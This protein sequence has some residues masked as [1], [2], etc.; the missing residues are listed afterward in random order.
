MAAELKRTVLIIDSQ[1]LWRT[2]LDA[3]LCGEF[4]VTIASSY[5]EA[6][7][8]L[9][10]QGASFQVVITEISLDEGDVNNEE[11]FE[12]IKHIQAAGKN[13][14]TIILTHHATVSRTRIAF[15]D[16][17]IYDLVEKAPAIEKPP[18]NEEAPA[19]E[20]SFDG[21]GFLELVRKAADEAMKSLYDIDAFVIMDFD[22]KYEEIYNLIEDVAEG[23]GLICK[24]SDR[25]PTIGPIME[26]IEECISRSKMVIADL[27][28]KNLNVYFEIGITEAKNRPLI[29]LA[30]DNNDLSRL[31]AGNRVILYENSIKGSTNL[32][33]QLREQIDFVQRN[34]EHFREASNQ[35]ISGKDCV[36]V[37]SETRAGKGGHKSVILPGLK[38]FTFDTQQIWDSFRKNK[39]KDVTRLIKENLRAAEII[40]VDLSGRDEDVYYMGG[41]AYGLDRYPIFLMDKHEEIPFD[42]RA[43][44]KILYS[45]DSRKESESAK[46]ELVNSIQTSIKVLD[47]IYTPDSEIT[48]TKKRLPKTKR[49]QTKRTKRGIK[50]AK[51]AKIKVFLNHARED[52]ALVRNLYAELK[53]I[54]WIDPWLD[55]VEILAGQDWALEIDK[56]MN[57]S[58]AC[59]VCMSKTSI[60]KT[61]YVQ[62]EIRKA[63][64][65]QSLRPPGSIYMIP[66]LLEKCVVPSNL[67]RYQ[68]V[69]ITQLG[70]M[71]QIIRSLETLR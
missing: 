25:I 29:L 15:R 45:T 71:D 50:V 4:L 38:N 12:V 66:V 41:Y 44:G 33:K 37:I 65:Q 7:D 69:D 43:I 61:G 3:L 51:K 20:T 63:E 49:I 27:S 55:E 19:P 48:G 13:V 52:K 18:G 46:K 28:D 42:L 70:Q 58:D 67:S 68:W 64:V 32:R 26:Q 56:A 36:V 22:E 60:K 30:R 34:G 8:H 21:K 6:L 16:Y 17:E 24:R 57:E 54:S 9:S 59:L 11:G 2:H 39:A 35:Q 14:K 62:A 10:K 53:K 23:L 31:L 5:S 40:I 1:P 47:G